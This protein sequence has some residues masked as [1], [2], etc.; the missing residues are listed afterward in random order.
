MINRATFY[1]HYKDKQD[2]Y[3]KIFDM[4]IDSFTSI[5]SL[6]DLVQ[7][8]RIKIKR[9]ELAMTKIYQHIQDNRLFFFLSDHHGWAQPSN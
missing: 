7:G 6:E 3:E 9:V 4:A 5:L 8:N 1:A 2:L